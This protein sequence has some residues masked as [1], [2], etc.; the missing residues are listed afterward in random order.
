[1]PNTFDN[2]VDKIFARGLMALRENAIMPRLVNTDWGSETAE[3]GDTITVPIPSAAEVGDV[4]P[5]P[6][7]PAGGNTA[8]TK[9]DITLD[10][11]RS[12]NMHVTDKEAREIATGARDLELS[13]HIKALANDVDQYLLGLF[14][15]VYGFVG[16]PGTTP[17]GGGGTPDL[18]EAV[19][20]RRVL[21]Q[22]L[23]PLGDRRLVLD[24]IAEANALL[25]RAVQDASHRR[26]GED[27]LS[28][29]LIGR[30]L[31]FDW[32]M[33]QNVQTHT[34]GTLTDGTAHRAL[35]DGAPTL[36][37]KTQDFNATSLTG[38]V[39]AGSVFT[40]AGDDQTY[41]VT[42]LATAAGNAVTLAFEPGVQVV[43]DNDAQMTLKGTP[44][45]T[46]AQ[47]LAFHRDAFALAVRP[48]AP[49]DGFTGGHLI[50]TGVDPVSGLAL[51]LEV[52]REHKRTKY[53]WSVLYG[54]KLVRP[55]LAT[56]MAG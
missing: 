14:G 3:Q 45:E 25:V 17:F 51:S 50:R 40:V 43:W 20:A 26:T 1:M 21:A 54:A 47:N 42:A 31:G 38:T 46:Y 56:R 52:S 33:D 39:T 6:T 13:E 30:V 34:N 22:Q 36:G 35:V 29:G 8:P 19:D 49:A 48:L 24:P 9:V 16:T 44:S 28:T 53:E 4:T 41:V 27:T 7:P 12:T 32:Y 55:E 10:R 15:G 18:Q 5:G 2:I 11:W 23:A 37:D